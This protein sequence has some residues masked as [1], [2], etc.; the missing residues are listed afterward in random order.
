MNRLLTHLSLVALTVAGYGCCG[1]AC[2]QIQSPETRQTMVSDYNAKPGAVCVL[3]GSGDYTQLTMICKDKNVEQL[4]A[5]GKA[6]CSMFR[7]LGVEKVDFEGSN[8]KV[9]CSLDDCTCK[10]SKKR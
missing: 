5:E 3:S 4:E 6:T 8:G 2:E 7:L 9:K 10:P 1:S